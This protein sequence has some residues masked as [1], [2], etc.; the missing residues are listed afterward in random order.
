MTRRIIPILIITGIVC[1][2]SASRKVANLSENAVAAKLQLSSDDEPMLPELDMIK[3]RSADTIHITGLNGEDMI[4]MNAVK[5]E[6]GEMVAHDVIDAAYV[7]ARFRNVA[8]RH[9]K[10]DLEFQVVVPEAMQDTKWQLRFYPDMYILEDSVRLESVIITG[11]DYRRAQ[12]KGYQQYQKFIDSI[13]SDTTKFINVWQLELFLERNIPEVY[14]FK[15][16]STEVSDEQFASV[17][18][19]TQRQAVDHYTNQFAKRWNNRKKTLTDKMYR[20]YVKVPIETEGIRLDTVIQSV[21]GDFIYNY[22]QTINTRPKL[23]KVDIVLSGEV[24]EADKK[25]YLMSR[26][27]PLTFYISSLSAFVDGTEK[28]LTK[29]IQ[30]RVEA[31]TACYVDFESGKAEI[32]E[33]LSNNAEEIRRIK[34]NLAQLIENEVFDLDSIVVTASASPE[35][36]IRTNESLALKRSESVSRYFDNYTRHYRD[37][38]QREKGFAIDEDGNILREEF[39]D[40]RFIAKNGGENWTMLENL[41]VK[42][43]ILTQDQKNQFCELKNTERDLD[44]LESELQRLPYYQHLKEDLYPKLRT[45]RFDFHLHRKGMIQESIQTTELDTTYMQGVQ[46]IRDRDYETAVTLLREYADYNTAVAYCA[47]DY[48]ASALS[49]LETLERSA[50]VNYM[51]AVVYTRLGRIQEAVQCYVNSCEQN[52]TFV[53]RGNLDPEISALIKTYGLNRQEDEEDYFN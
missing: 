16:D 46:A 1:A 32:K 25:L 30:R 11:K 5:D 19:V 26:S 17:Y 47:L 9:G 21:N 48:N 49:I 8:E 24:W 34:G 31:N 43:T 12:L 50:E 51:L 14:A 15:T 20:R 3:S 29:I 23:R 10:I 42:D 41:V 22:V 45:V 40:I 52:Q 36:S 2:C 7:T 4:L 39:Q 18:G 33:G 27:E 35:G 13:V 53:H 6:D 38:L 44:K 28:Y 37:S